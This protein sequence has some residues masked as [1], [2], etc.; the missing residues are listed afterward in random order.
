MQIN[1]MKI[2]EK[3]PKKGY[4]YHYKHDPKGSVNN[5]AYEMVAVVMHTE[6]GCR[7]ED[8]FMVIYKPLYE[9][10]A[11]KAGKFFDLRPIEMWMGSVT[12]DGKTF[13][14]FKRIT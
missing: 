7:P 2:P 12:K 1:F 4:Y 14:R 11:F 8:A 10:R 13:K 3:V 5:Y 6:D 9:S